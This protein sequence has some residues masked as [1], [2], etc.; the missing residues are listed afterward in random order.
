M[1]ALDTLTRWFDKLHTLA[2]NIKFR[3]DLVTVEELLFEA[4]P[5]LD[6]AAEV[7]IGITSSKVLAA[8]MAVLHTTFPHLFDGTEHTPDEASAYVLAVASS[9]LEM[10]APHINTTIARAA[11]QLAYMYRKAHEASN[12]SA[13]P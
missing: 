6:M 5:Y 11:V 1:K 12:A 3:D 13:K 4:L 2:K 7:A 10:R 9:L 8:E